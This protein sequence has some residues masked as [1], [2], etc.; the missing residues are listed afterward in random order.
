MR[1][2]MWFAIGFALAA[3]VG[4]YA[5]QGEWY[6]LASGVAALPLCLCLWLMRRFPKARIG[7]VLLLGCIAGFVWLSIFDGAYLS[8]SRAADEKKMM[9]TVTATDYSYETDYGSAVEGTCRLNDKIYAIRV[10]LPKKAD[11]APGDTLTGRYTL[12]STLPGGSSESSYTTSNGTFL[13]AKISRLP[14]IVKAEK[15]PWYGY[16]AYVRQQ[17]KTVLHSVFPEDAAGFAVAL[18]IGDTDGIDYQTDTSFKISGISHIIAVSGFH[19]TVLF[20]MV[21]FLVGK[22]RFLAAAAG[23][24]VLFFF[25]AVAGFSASIMR[26]CLMHSLMIIA[27]VFDREYDPPTALGFAVLTMLAVNPWTVTNVGFQLSVGCMV[28]ILLFAEPIK[29]WIME[30]KCMTRLKGKWKGLANGFAISVGMSVGATIM[31]TPLCACYFGMVSLVSVITNLLT[32]WVITA[33]FYGVMAAC[34]IGLIWAPVGRL[35]AWIVAWPIRYVLTAAKLMA[36]FPFA[37]VYTD[38]I[39]TVL[40]LIF[41]YILLAI[42]ILSKGKQ[43]V[44]TC[45]CAVIGLCISL[46]A[47]WAQPLADECRVT[48][49]DVGQGQCILLQSEGKTFMVDCGGDS[50]TQAADIAAKALLSQGV[51]QLDGLILTHYDSDHA[52]GAAYLLSRIPADMLYLPNCADADGTVSA[53]QSAHSGQQLVVDRDTCITFGGTTITLFPSRS[54][55]SD[56]ESG[57]CVLF[58]TENCDILITGDRSAA[59]E[60]ELMRHIELPELEVLIVGHH[61]SKYS[62][63]LALLEQTSPE[64]AIISVGQDN[65]FGHPTEETIQRLQEAGCEIYRTD[66]HGKVVYRR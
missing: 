32:T 51:Y 30:R 36:A 65:P 59:G 66:L 48:V 45:S 5:L 33:I 34:L 35:L 9:L 28:G 8:V 21:Y 24:P 61:G 14:T 60:R 25:A 54:D 1:K 62:T 16:P 27:M 38:S 2:L 4:L 17:I 64:V 57:L 7:A 46:T 55:L 44:L 23:L 40:W 3:A 39:Y 47:S 37:A 6:F 18:L 20:S 11:I 41:A 56:N 19:V 12:R 10:Y 63:S 43:L 15:L 53:L 50:D 13:T 58:Q 52:A 26:A 29:Q 22:K 42:F 31:V 49:L